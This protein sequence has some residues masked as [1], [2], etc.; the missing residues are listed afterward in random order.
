MQSD[1]E[2]H[3]PHITVYLA[4]CLQLPSCSHAVLGL[5][6]LGIGS[7]LINPFITTDLFL[8]MPCADSVAPDQPAHPRSLT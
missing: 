6:V 1:L 8:Y 7:N 2:L 3:C 4:L 5:M